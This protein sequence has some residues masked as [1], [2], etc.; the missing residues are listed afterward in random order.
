MM[1]SELLIS[2]FLL[3]CFYSFAQNKTTSK[4]NTQVDSLVN[5]EIKSQR[6]PGLSLVVVRDGKLTDY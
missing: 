1:K 6:I 2:F 3:Q 4:I 5:A